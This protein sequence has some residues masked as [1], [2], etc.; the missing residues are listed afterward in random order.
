[1]LACSEIERYSRASGFAFVLSNMYDV[2]L[3]CNCKKQNVL[4]FLCTHWWNRI[5]AR[6]SSL[7]KCCCSIWHWTLS[8]IWASRQFRHR[9]CVLLLCLLFLLILFTFSFSVR[10]VITP[11]AITYYGFEFILTGD[12]RILFSS[13]LRLLDFT[14]HHVSCLECVWLCVV[15][16][17][18]GYFGF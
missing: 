13:L 17:F 9:T 5:V 11:N 8:I 2:D 7:K 14:Q 16:V 18:I 10:S 6:F 15:F 12:F 1:M 3:L 4:R